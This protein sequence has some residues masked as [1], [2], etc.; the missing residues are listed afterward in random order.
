FCS[1]SMVF[2]SVYNPCAQ[3]ERK[4]E[5]RHTLVK[6]GTTLGANSTI[7]CGVTLGE[8]AFIGAG[9]VINKDVKPYALMVGVPTRQIGWMSKHGEQIPL[10]LSD[11]GEY[12]CPHSGQHYRLTDQHLE[13]LHP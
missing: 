3:I 6:R 12:T 8:Y 10:P 5:Y 9:A 2:T 4:D 13:C 11:S 1:P 7:I